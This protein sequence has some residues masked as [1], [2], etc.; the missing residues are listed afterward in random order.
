MK[1]SVIYAYPDELITIKAANKA[2]QRP[3]HVPI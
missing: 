2:M 3:M 1:K